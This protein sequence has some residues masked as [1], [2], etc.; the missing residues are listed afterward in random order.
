VNIVDALRDR[1]LLGAL[2]A[3]RDLASWGAWLV[4]AKAVYGLPMSADERATF[5]RCTN[6]SA[7]RVGGYAEAVAIVGRQSGKTQIA[8]AI[9]TYEALAARGSGGDLYS[10]LCAQDQRGAVRTLF[11][12]A[13]EAFEVSAVLRSSVANR[14]ADALTLKNGTVLAAYP[15]RPG[16]VRGL[17]ARVVV[18]DE[19]AFFRGA[20]G[21]LMDVEMLRA[22]RPC[23]AMTGGKVV[24][25][26]SPYS[27]VGALYE[28]HRKHY[29]RDDSSTLIW[30]ADAPSMN[31][32]LPRDY[33]ERMRED[34]PEAARAEID[35]EF[36]SGLSTFLD[37]DALAA[38]V[39]PDRRELPWTPDH[40]YHAVCD[41]SGGRRDAFTAAVCHRERG[42]VVVDVLRAWPAPFNPTGPVAEIAETLRTYRVRSITG[43]RFA[44]EWPR[45]AFRA[46]GITYRVAELDRSALYGELLPAVQAGT[47]ELPDDAKLLRELRGL[48]RRRGSSGKDRIDHRPGEHDDRANSIALAAYVAGVGH[49][50]KG[51]A[52][53]GWSPH[54]G[55]SSIG[56]RLDKNG[57]A[58][59]SLEAGERIVDCSRLRSVLIEKRVPGRPP[60]YVERARPE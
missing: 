8:S 16:S 35:G 56:V 39:I 55:E 54:N 37:P 13:V 41:P 2:P 7:P 12:Y 34:D 59:P 1:R 20:E 38:C 14:V 50:G 18:A 10:I 47:I 53:F 28:L 52:G 22:L 57:F 11:R 46:H 23:V 25:L 40:T 4:F 49:T 42:R 51:R 36:R 27:Q 43:D 31:P 26:S 19:L 30:Q 48:E 60:V 45:E 32:A 5:T 33:L 29:G 58:L 24:V 9:A 6:R 3:F 21:N 15:C 44:G 17:R